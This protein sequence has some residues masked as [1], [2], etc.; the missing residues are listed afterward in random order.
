[1]ICIVSTVFVDSF[2]FNDSATTV[3][4]TY[5]HTLS[6]HD[7]LPICTASEGAEEG[8][9]GSSSSLS[10]TQ[11]IGSKPPGRTTSNCVATGSISTRSEEHT[12]ELQSLMRNSY[13]VFCL[14]KKKQVNHSDQSE[15]S[16]VRTTLVLTNSLSHNMLNT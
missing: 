4:Y 13:A 11:P 1:M 8:S 7:A 12:S 9:S 6:L 14:Q 15:R 16:H 2:F 10:S 5:L 3:S